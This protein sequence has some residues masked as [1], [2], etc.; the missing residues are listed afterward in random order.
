MLPFDFDFSQESMQTIGAASEVSIYG[1]TEA[2]R[3]DVLTGMLVNLLTK[4][5][6]MRITQNGKMAMSLCSS[7]I[8]M[9]VDVHLSTGLQDVKIVLGEN[10]ALPGKECEERQSRGASTE[11]HTDNKWDRFQSDSESD[12][13]GSKRRQLTQCML[14]N[15]PAVRIR[16]TFRQSPKR[17]TSQNYLS[18]WSPF[19]P[20]TVST[21]V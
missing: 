12:E 11:A 21:R 20:F 1:N 13:E 3:H 17:L 19:S 9:D 2:S 15:F 10:N 5:A 14:T 8:K 16:L 18:G 4:E 6:R 7:I